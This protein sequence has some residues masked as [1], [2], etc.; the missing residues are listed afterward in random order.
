MKRI[1]I[2]A[3]VFVLLASV[4]FA[5]FGGFV[6]HPFKAYS[7]IPGVGVFP[8][9]D[10]LDVRS[11]EVGLQWVYVPTEDKFEPYAVVRVLGQNDGSPW[12]TQLDDGHVLTLIA[13]QEK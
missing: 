2:S 13:Q 1:R 3:A 11:I 7:T 12:Q 8:Y 6:T 10:H 5:A 9:P 4:A